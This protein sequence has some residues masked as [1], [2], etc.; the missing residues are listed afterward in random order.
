MKRLLAPCFILLTLIC[1]AACSSEPSNSQSADE[2]SQGTG[3][4]QLTSKKEGVTIGAFLRGAAPDE[5]AAKAFER[6]M[7]LAAEAKSPPN[8]IRTT[9]D[10]AQGAP[11]NPSLK[12]LLATAPLV[13]YWQTADLVPAAPILKESGVIAVPVWNVTEKVASLGTKV[14]G[15][16]YSTERS[17]AEFAKFAGNK[18]KSYRFAVLSSSAEPFSTQSSAFIEETKSLGNTIVFEEKVESAG[19]DF[20]ALI[21]RAKKEKCDTIFA[22][23]PGDALV[24]FIKSARE[25]AFGGKILVGDSFFAAE[26][27]MTGKDSEGIYLLQAWSD[28]AA[29]KSQYTAKYGAEPDGITLGAAALGYDLIKCIEAAGS[30]LDPESISYS[31]LSTPCEGL[32]GK[33]Q[34]SGERIAQRSKRIL[35]VKGEKFELAG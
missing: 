31:W 11:E 22:V 24:A 28:D 34:F 19:T 25:N 10:R 5:A 4:K 21:A 20:K 15:F 6:G 8:L 3:D 33:T 27:E 2:K 16:G 13:I 18:L 1:A 7:D 9:L 32:T 26:R 23:L 14:F 12:P 30:N 17:F 29:F 35:T